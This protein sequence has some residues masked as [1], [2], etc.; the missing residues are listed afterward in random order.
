MP[1]IEAQIAKVLTYGHLTR[2]LVALYAH[3]VVAHAS[4][5]AAGTFTVI[6]VYQHFDDSLYAAL[7]AFGGLYFGTGILTPFAARLLNYCGI[8]TL[9]MTG[10]PLLAL[11]NVGLFL[12][13]SE[14]VSNESSVFGVLL[15][16]IGT[17]ILYRALYWVPYNTDMS[18]LLDQSRRGTQVAL[19]SNFADVNVAVMPF[20]AGIVVAYFGF[21]WL[22]IL[23][24]TLDILALIP[25][26]WIQNHREQFDWSYGET[27][28]ELF[29]AQ[30][31]PLLYG[32]VATGVQ[33]AVQLVV[34]PLVV[35]LLLNGEYVTFGAITALTFFSILLIR[36]LTGRLFDAGKKTRVLRWGA[37]L[38]ASGWILK[39]TVAT[40]VAIFMVDT[41]HGVG[42]I[43]N[44]TAI[45]IFAFE[46]AADNG[47]FVDEYTVLKEMALG[48]GRT[49]ALALVGVGMWF[50]GLAIGF[51]VGLSI[52]A[53]ATF[54]TTWLSQRVCIPK[55]V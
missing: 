24:A 54:G 50:G 37:A 36:F 33:D 6:F 17:A 30:T 32:Y 16:C 1:V 13:A 11:S 2:E 42:R 8:R 48:L 15:F 20:W 44:H 22:F 43:M 34:W 46:Q 35:F 14:R 41:Y 4:A 21:D 19:L 49:L 28:R 31:R 27:V 23:A 10:M 51:A 53:M 29:S 52:A 47:R 39:M 3:R 38:S 25:L 26:M 12:I 45:D 40:P 18:L 9:L 5:A 7:L 55:G